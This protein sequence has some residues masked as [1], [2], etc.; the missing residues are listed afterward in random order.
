MVVSGLRR[1]GRL[2]VE[3]DFGASV[4]GELLNVT[5]FRLILLVDDDLISAA[6]KIG[7]L[8]LILKSVCVMVFLN[9]SHRF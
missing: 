4:F 6:F 1:P 9:S 7:C 2:K 8:A 3:L 5:L